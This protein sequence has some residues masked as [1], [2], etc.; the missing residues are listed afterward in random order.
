MR[1]LSHYETFQ[2]DV[3]NE[4]AHADTF[5]SRGLLPDEFSRWEFCRSAH[6]FLA[7]KGKQLVVYRIWFDTPQVVETLTCQEASLSLLGGISS[8]WTTSS[9]QLIGASH[10]PV[11]IA[12]SCF[13]WHVFDSQVRFMSHDQK[14]SV[15]L[16]LAYKTKSHPSTMNEDHLYVLEKAVFDN[17]VGAKNK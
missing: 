5:A 11:E 10:T 14:Y 1:L 6:R 9:G 7:Y 16:P 17:T 2:M 15:S 3:R 4:R 12:P 13:L 8:N